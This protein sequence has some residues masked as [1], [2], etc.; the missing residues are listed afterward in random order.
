VT[1]N[2][3]SGAAAPTG[4]TATTIGTSATIISPVSSPNLRTARIASVPSF[5]GALE[6]ERRGRLL[7]AMCHLNQY[8][9]IERDVRPQAPPPPFP[10]FGSGVPPFSPDG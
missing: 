2:A 3:T 10:L 4:E 7:Q 6:V 1:A 8:E 5:A 9:V